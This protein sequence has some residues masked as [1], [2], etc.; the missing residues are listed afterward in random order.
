[1]QTVYIHPAILPKPTG[2]RMQPADCR[3]ETLLKRVLRSRTVRQR[4]GRLRGVC[5]AW[6]GLAPWG[7]KAPKA[8]MS[9]TNMCTPLNTVKSGLH[10]LGDKR[11]GW[12][13]DHVKLF[14]TPLTGTQPNR[15]SRAGPLRNNRACLPKLAQQS[16]CTHT[17]AGCTLPGPGATE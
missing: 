14:L 11:A 15:N 5:K 13:G 16:L 1:M 17:T 8:V 6:G 10:P 3:T 12:D 9:H 4:A 2:P 7:R